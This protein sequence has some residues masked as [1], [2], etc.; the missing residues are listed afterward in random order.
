MSGICHTLETNTPNLQLSSIGMFPTLSLL[1][2]HTGHTSPSNDEVR[3]TSAPSTQ[4]RK[5]R[6]RPPRATQNS[7]VAHLFSLRVSSLPRLFPVP[8]QFLYKARQANPSVRER[9]GCWRRRGREGL[10]RRRGRNRGTGE[11]ELP[12][13]RPRRTAPLSM[14]ETGRRLHRHVLAGWGSGEAC[15]GVGMVVLKTRVSEG[16]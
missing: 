15:A 12:R 7:L 16:L 3:S 5:S 13:R 6:L 11:G 2:Q 9:R 8:L 10:L 4:I 1:S 14:A